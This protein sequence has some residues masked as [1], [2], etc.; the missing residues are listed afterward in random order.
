[1]A[2]VIVNPGVCGMECTIEVTKAD[3]MNFVVKIETKCEMVKKLAEGIS[4][5]NLRNA[6]KA[7]GGNCISEQAA[8][9]IKHPT[10]PIPTAILK[11]IEVEAGMALPRPITITFE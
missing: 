3:R 6:L 2:R 7:F 10:C 5:I 8:E 9:V 11:A 4:E 1:M